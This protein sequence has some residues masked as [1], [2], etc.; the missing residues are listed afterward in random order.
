MN[1][2]LLELVG[3]LSQ[4]VVNIV[5]IVAAVLGAYRFR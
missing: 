2:E 1:R 5:I 3:L 4:V